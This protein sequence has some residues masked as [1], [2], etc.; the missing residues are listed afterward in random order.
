MAKFFIL[1]VLF[2]SISVAA[3]TEFFHSKINLSE[4]KLEEFYSSFSIDDAQVYFNANDYQVYAY[5]KKTGDL[6]WSYYSG[7]KTNTAPISVQEKLF[8]RITDGKLLQM[9]PK[10][11]DTIQTLK[12]E[13]LYTPPFFKD[14]IMY[15]AA[16]LP[17]IGGA[18]LA[19]DLNT[20]N[21]LWQKYIGHG[22]SYQ[23]YFLKDKIV[24]RFEDMFW[25]ELDY[26]GN[27]LDKSE[28]CYSKNT[29]PPFEEYFCNIQY[30][31]VNQYHKDLATKNVT[32]DETKYYYGANETVVLKG[33]NLKIINNKN[34]VAT[35]ISIDKIITLLETEANDYTA[36]LKVEENTVWFIYENILA[37]Y[38]FKNNKTVKAFD[39]SKWNPHQVI[40]DG[41]NLWLISRKDGELVGLKL[42]LDP[43]DEAIRAAKAK[44]FNQTHQC[45]NEAEALNEARKKALDTVKK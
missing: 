17:E 20:N 33:N 9:N 18:I 7:Y 4:N 26:N 39:L 31:I 10:N 16:I 5:D 42:E 22:A 44:L 40:L 3:Q 2:F 19:Y 37:V 34:K 25:F 35:E 14:N 1:I 30:D 21:I 13:K 12:I 41:N 27:A 32:I 24:A 15:C 38:D 8:S 45:G 29:E 43:A 6:N 11:G 28:N 23:P 36:I